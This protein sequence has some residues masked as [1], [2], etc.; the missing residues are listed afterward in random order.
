MSEPTDCLTCEHPASHHD[1]GEC[2][3]TAGGYETWGQTACK[4]GWYEPIGPAPTKVEAPTVSASDLLG[5]A[6]DWTGGMSTE[7]WVREQR[8]RT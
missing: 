2:W 4:C 6:P 3:T 1:A 7:D 8:D 5:I